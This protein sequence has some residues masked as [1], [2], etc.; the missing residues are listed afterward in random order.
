MQRVTGVGGIFFKSENPEALYQW[1]EKHLGIKRNPD[2]SGVIFKASN[3]DMTVWS[4]FPQSTKYFEPTV[5]PFMV[6]YRVADLDALIEALRAEGV[7]V[8]DKRDES[9][10]K[11]AWIRDC[12]GNRIELWEPERES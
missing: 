4:V 6:N 8:D 9:Y 7:W 11:F 2:G 5:A 1:Y 10:G 3:G 12:D